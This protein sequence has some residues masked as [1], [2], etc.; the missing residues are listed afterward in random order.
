MK[1]ESEFVQSHQPYAAD[2]SSLKVTER[3]D[4]TGSG[5]GYFRAEVT[6]AWFRR[7][8]PVGGAMIL[9]QACIGRLWDFQ[10]AE[11]ADAKAFLTTHTDGR[12]GGDC[13]AR[14]D[15]MSLWAPA[16]TEPERADYLAVLKP[17]LAAYPALPDG[18]DGW[19]TF[20]A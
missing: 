9:T 8:R 19:W 10:D 5:A 18:F 12:Y 20:R 2:L 15:G 17:M 13:Q 1:R 11:P 3:V 4:R 14:W 7:K 16:R 6:V